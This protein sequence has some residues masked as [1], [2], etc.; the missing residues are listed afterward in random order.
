MELSLHDVPTSLHQ[1]HTELN[2]SNGPVAELST[3][4]KSA[5]DS[6]SRRYL[7]RVALAK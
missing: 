3:H 2:A 6:R 5:I 4:R 7:N 1:Y